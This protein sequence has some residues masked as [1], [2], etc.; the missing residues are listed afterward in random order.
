MSSCDMGQILDA[1]LNVHLGSSIRLGSHRRRRI[2]SQSVLEKL[3]L[4]GTSTRT[5]ANI[6]SLV[7]K[8]RPTCSADRKKYGYRT[9]YYTRRHAKTQGPCVKD[10]E[11]FPCNIGINQKEFEHL[12]R[13][14]YPSDSTI[15]FMS[16]GRLVPWKG[17]HLS[18]Q[19]FALAKLIT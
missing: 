10:V 13:M 15:R 9:Q 8:A 4:E 16:L 19:A 18:L 3:W 14:N 2:C 11:Y 6:H 1:K 12:G 7:S 5:F 17:I